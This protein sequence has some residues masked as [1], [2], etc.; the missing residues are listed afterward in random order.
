MA[1]K[2]WSEEELNAAD[3]RDFADVEKFPEHWYE[4]K[5][6]ISIYDDHD[7][8]RCILEK[9]VGKKSLYMYVDISN[10][11]IERMMLN[12]LKMGTNYFEDTLLAMG[13]KWESYS[14]KTLLGLN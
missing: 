11:E 14:K 12:S 6:G 1:G 3:D 13:L 7:I 2:G 4:K 5:Y 8:S 9:K 10:Y